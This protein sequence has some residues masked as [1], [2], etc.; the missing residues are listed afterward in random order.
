MCGRHGSAVMT[1]PAPLFRSF[2]CV[3]ILRGVYTFYSFIFPFFSFIHSFIHF[4]I[5]F[6]LLFLIWILNS[7]KNVCCVVFSEATVDRG[8]RGYYLALPPMVSC[9][10]LKEERQQIRGGKNEEIALLFHHFVW[11]F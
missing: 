3:Y 8:K 10:P 11:L 5:Y 9:V 1:R 7:P 2:F 6:C 4:F